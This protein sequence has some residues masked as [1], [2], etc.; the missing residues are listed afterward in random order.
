MDE[1]ALPGCLG[2]MTHYLLHVTEG[3]RRRSVGEVREVLARD[4]G[5]P[6]G[7]QEIILDAIGSMQRQTVQ[8]ARQLQRHLQMMRSN[9]ISSQLTTRPHDKD[10][11]SGEYSSLTSGKKVVHVIEDL[12][13]GRIT[14]I[15]SLWTLAENL[16]GCWAARLS[17]GSKL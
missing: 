6:Q 12:Q 16:P 5:T 7:L 13:G 14:G 10:D 2:I 11:S 9:T 15:R 4:P 1:K 3:R 17:F 8:Y